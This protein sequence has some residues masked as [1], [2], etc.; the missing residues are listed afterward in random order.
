[1]THA[2]IFIEDH[3]REDNSFRKRLSGFSLLFGGGKSQQE[4]RK[5]WK[6][7]GRVK[8]GFFLGQQYANKSY[9]FSSL[10]DLN[11]GLEKEFRDKMIKLCQD[12][13]MEITWHP[14]EGMI[15]KKDVL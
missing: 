14:T 11:Q 13:N 8:N 4:E 3:L 5:I 2:D 1:M 6:K 10:I 7:R 9:N 15:I 12:Y